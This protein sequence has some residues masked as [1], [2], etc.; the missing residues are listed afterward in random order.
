[1]QAGSRAYRAIAQ[2]KRPCSSCAFARTSACL[3]IRPPAH[4]HAAGA[5][6]NAAS[7]E[8]ESKAAVIA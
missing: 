3:R 5:V 2:I 4:S 1:M 7:A 6:E 8:S